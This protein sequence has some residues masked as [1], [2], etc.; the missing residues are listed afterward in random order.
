[1]RKLWAKLTGADCH[2]GETGTFT[3]YQAA[4]GFRWR[5]TAH[6]NRIVADSGE[7]Y[8]RLGDAKRAVHA[9]EKI[10]HRASM[11]VIS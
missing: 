2:D 11:K 9:I 1:M 3:I 7:S 4:D 5:L 8:T 10:A 6:N